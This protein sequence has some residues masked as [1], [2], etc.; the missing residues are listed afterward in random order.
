MSHQNSLWALIKKYKWNSIFYRYAIMLFS[1]VIFP[2]TLLT[3]LFFYRSNDINKKSQLNSQC[4]FYEQRIP[5]RFSEIMNTVYSTQNSLFKNQ[6]LRDYFYFP[7]MNDNERSIN[8]SQIYSYILNI[9]QSSAY[10]DSIYLYSNKTDYVLSSIGCSFADKFPDMAW[11]SAYNSAI[12]EN[13]FTYRS[14]TINAE[15]KRYLTICNDASIYGY[16]NEKVVY[17][18]DCDKLPDLLYS[19]SEFIDKLYIVNSSNTIVYSNDENAISKKFDF[20]KKSKNMVICAPNSAYYAAFTYSVTDDFGKTY[21]SMLITYTLITLLVMSVTVLILSKRF[22]CSIVDIIDI[23]QNNGSGIEYSENEFQ[24]LSENI[25]KMMKRNAYFENEL[26]V[27]YNKLKR[28]QAIA[29]QNQI[30]PHFI[31]NVLNTVTLLDIKQNDHPS[32]ITK[33]ID[34]LSDILRATI[35]SREYIVPL[36]RELSYVT[37]YIE[38]QNIKYK[39]KFSFETKISPDTE[40]I[41]VIKFMLQPIVENSIIHGILKAPA[42]RGLIR[43]NSFLSADNLI[44]EVSNSGADIDKETLTAINQKLK[45]NIFPNDKHIGL[46]NVNSRIKLIFGSSYGCTMLRANNITTVRILLPAFL[47]ENK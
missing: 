7:N 14:V 9:C 28:T 19:S 17:N 26:A 12:S 22:F 18:I 5:S 32:D 13:Y 45:Y 8:A 6:S 41:R 34:L 35:S 23:F 27:Q 1:L 2:V 37:K 16:P 36:E 29:L 38:L 15:T 40:N 3:F 21:A 42:L 39:D 24:Y 33:I 25:N 11:L 10:I 20:Y 47:D 44:I 4:S 46:L 43:V 31:F 30:N